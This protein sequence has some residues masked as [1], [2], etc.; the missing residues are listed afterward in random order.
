MLSYCVS[1][2]EEM[3]LA[4]PY[5]ADHFAEQ[6]S[7]DCPG[8]ATEFLDVDVTGVDCS[9]P[10]ATVSESAAGSVRAQHASTLLALAGAGAAMMMTLF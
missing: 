3:M 8:I 1:G 9:L 10:Y 5:R 6:F 7:C 2:G 4:G